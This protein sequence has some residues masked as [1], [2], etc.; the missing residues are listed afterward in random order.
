[1]KQAIKDT[2]LPEFRVQPRIKIAALLF[3]ISKY[4]ITKSTIWI[5]YLWRH[6]CWSQWNM[7]NKSRSWIS[8]WSYLTKCLWFIVTKYR[9]S[10]FNKRQSRI[11]RHIFMFLQVAAC[12]HIEWIFRSTWKIQ[13]L[14]TSSSIVNDFFRTISPK[15]N[16]ILSKEYSGNWYLNIYRNNTEFVIYLLT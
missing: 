12:L 14:V 2:H 7:T 9:L 6:Y 10:I 8:K 1:M 4:C 16:L 13:R 3:C 5:H 11:Q 15:E